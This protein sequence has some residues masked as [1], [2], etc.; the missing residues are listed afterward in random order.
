[1][2]YYNLQINKLEY[3]YKLD[4]RNKNK[5]LLGLNKINKSLKRF[6][7]KEKQ[8]KS[9]IKF[10]KIFDIWSSLPVTHAITNQT[11][12]RLT[13]EFGWDPVLLA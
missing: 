6:V 11:L 9:S 1:M 7:A 13:S 5:I 2:F 12:N 3:F 10:D 4:S 8:K